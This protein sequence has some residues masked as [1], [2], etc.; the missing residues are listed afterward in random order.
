S[1]SA[2]SSVSASPR[3]ATFRVWLTRSS[4]GSPVYFR[5]EPDMPLHTMATSASEFDIVGRYPAPAPRLQWCTAGAMCV[6]K[7]GGEAGDGRFNDDK[8]LVMVIV[9]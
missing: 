1:G 6:P 7:N 9:V 4:M 2:C 5:A 8:I 3:C